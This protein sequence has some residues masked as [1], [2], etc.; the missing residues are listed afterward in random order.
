MWRKLATLSLVLVIPVLAAC[1]AQVSDGSPAAARQVLPARVPQGRP[2]AASPAVAPAA[3]ARRIVFLGDSLTAGLGL[4]EDQAY[5]AVIERELAEAGTQVHVINAGVSGD[6]SA[7][8]L[9][10]L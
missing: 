1:G 5:P 3:D 10:R 6:T 2:A 4:D 9:S 8:G 7:G